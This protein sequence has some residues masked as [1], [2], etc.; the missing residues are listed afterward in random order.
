MDAGIML[1]TMV[2]ASGPPPSVHVESVDTRFLETL[3]G[4]NARRTAL[5]II[6]GFL[7]GMAVYGL[8]PVDFSILSLIHHNPGITSR[9]LCSSLGILPPNLVGRIAA[10]SK[11]GLL[12]RRPH[13]HDGRA[14]GLHLTP[15]GQQFMAQ[16]E[17]K[18]GQLEIESTPRLSDEE[19]ATLIR[20]LQK[21]Y[22]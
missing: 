14:V 9:Q 6:D 8:R 20:L 12:Q 3:L 7:Q 2:A 13:P 18:A 17:V 15:A 5:F 19:R 22:R 16:A 1:C 21:I 10:L 4:Y 11:R